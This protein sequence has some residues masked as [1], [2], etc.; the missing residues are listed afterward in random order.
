LTVSEHNDN[1]QTCRINRSTNL[2][3]KGNTASIGRRNAHKMKFGRFSIRVWFAQSLNLL[4]AKAIGRTIF[5]IS[6]L[7]LCCVPTAIHS[8]SSRL[9]QSLGVV[10]VWQYRLCHLIQPMPCQHLPNLSA[11]GLRNGF[12]TGILANL[13]G[14]RELTLQLARWLRGLYGILTGTAVRSMLK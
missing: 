13:V 6:P 5:T 2:Y 3:R 12:S 8:Q 11:L 10:P 1:Y 9:R 7:L 14:R 4:S